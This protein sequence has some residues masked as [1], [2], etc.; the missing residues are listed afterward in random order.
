MFSHDLIL[1]GEWGEARLVAMKGTRRRLRAEEERQQVIRRETR[2]R[3]IPQVFQKD[4]RKV[5]VRAVRLET[6]HLHSR[7]EEESSDGN[8]LG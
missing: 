7:R 5:L 3:S 4:S 8:D 1:R 2:Q 6:L